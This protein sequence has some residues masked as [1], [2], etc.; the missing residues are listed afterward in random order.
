M[1]LPLWVRLVI[2]FAILSVARVIVLTREQ[3]RRLQRDFWAYV[4]QQATVR[5]ENAVKEL[6]RRYE[7]TGDWSFL[8][9]RPRS[10]DAYIEG[11]RTAVDAAETEPE[12]R[13]PRPPDDAPQRGSERPVP[14]L[15][16]PPRRRTEDGRL[17]PQ[18]KFEARIDALS[19]PSRV[20][21]IN[22][23]GHRVIGNPAVPA[24]S[25]SLPIRVGAE[26]VG[27]LLLAPQSAL[28]N[29][30]D[31]AFVRSQMSHAVMAGVAVTIAA[32]FAACG[33]AC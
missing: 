15:D 29:D 16:D 3:R 24:N 8:A 7:Q 14:P 10:F 21:L 33:L 22:D 18:P 6:G 12:L 23:R 5:V 30:L 25:P 13:P 26:V 1:R 20:A 31:V 2:T 27:S 11:R 28:N 32:L 17:M 19:L 4:N 9:G